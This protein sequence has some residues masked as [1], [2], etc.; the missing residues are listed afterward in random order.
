MSKFYWTTIK[1]IDLINYLEQNDSQIHDIVVC[2][3]TAK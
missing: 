3:S 2:R 1:I